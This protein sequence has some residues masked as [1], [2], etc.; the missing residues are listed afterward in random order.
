[1]A[2]QVTMVFEILGRPADHVKESLTSLVLKLGTEQGVK[3]VEKTIHDPILVENQKDLFTSFAEVTLDL[4]SLNNYFGVMFAYMPANVELIHPEK[5]TLANIDLN[6]LGNKLVS[7][8]HEYDA[9]TKKALFEM[10][11]FKKKLYEVA[12]HL[13][14]KKDKKEE[15][16][17]EE[18]IKEEETKKKKTKKSKKE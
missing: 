1:M 4:E 11:F 15:T 16:K 13:F 5:I 6:E 8:L 10:D 12:P 18:P 3:V 7:R 14:K 17:T 2:L 9:I